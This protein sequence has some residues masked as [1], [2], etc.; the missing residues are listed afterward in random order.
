MQ[1]LRERN[2][3]ESI[4]GSSSIAFGHDRYGQTRFRGIQ[5]F[6]SRERPSQIPYHQPS[7][8]HTHRSRQ[9]RRRCRP[10]CQCTAATPYPHSSPEGLQTTEMEVSAHA[11]TATQQSTRGDS[12]TSDTAFVKPT[13]RTRCSREIYLCTYR[14]WVLVSKQARRSREELQVGWHEQ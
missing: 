5:V 14:V 1:I 8:K 9:S 12:F 10:P 13:K 2:L 11:C 3:A 7:H 4:E 6:S